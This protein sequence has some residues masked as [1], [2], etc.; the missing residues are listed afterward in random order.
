M[1]HHEKAANPALVTGGIP[2]SLRFDMRPAGLHFEPVEPQE[3]ATVALHPPVR[4]VIAR[5]VIGSECA[6]G[7]EAH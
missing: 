1:I 2:A 3:A 5:A 7:L 6:F 4:H